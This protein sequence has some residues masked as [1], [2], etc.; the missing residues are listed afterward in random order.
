MENVQGEY[1][2]EMSDGMFRE[3]V[4]ECLRELS[5]G[6]SEKCLGGNVRALVNTHTHKLV[7]TGCTINSAS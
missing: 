7:L 4:W 1:R 3:I 5:G 6:I 2:G